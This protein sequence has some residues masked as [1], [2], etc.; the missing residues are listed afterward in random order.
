[1]HRYL[2]VNRAGSINLPFKK[3]AQPFSKWGDLNQMAFG[4]NGL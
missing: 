1:M 4:L 2:C 3:E